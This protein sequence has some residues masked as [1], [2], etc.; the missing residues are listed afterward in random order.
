M[1]GHAG[2]LY[3]LACLMFGYRFSIFAQSFWLAPQRL[4]DVGSGYPNG[5]PTPHSLCK[6][7]TY[8]SLSTQTVHLPLTVYNVQLANCYLLN[9]KYTVQQ[10]IKRPPFF[11][12]YTINNI[13]IRR[14]TVSNIHYTGI[15]FY[16]SHYMNGS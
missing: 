6:R 15:L 9:D 12:Y 14:K 10:H 1:S 2:T 7:Y 4:D 11:L 13:S 3:E 8:P 5:T 16:F